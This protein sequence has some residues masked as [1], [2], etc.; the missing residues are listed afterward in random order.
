MLKRGDGVEFPWI[1]AIEHYF[2]T[3]RFGFISAD[4]ARAI[5]GGPDR[6]IEY[7]SNSCLHLC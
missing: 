6:K 1:A 5:A 3:M 4:V 2:D 7:V